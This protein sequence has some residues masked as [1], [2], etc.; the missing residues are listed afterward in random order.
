MYQH[1]GVYNGEDGNETVTDELIDSESASGLIFADDPATTDVLSEEIDKCKIHEDDEEGSSSDF[2]TAAEN[3]S[4]DDT[5][6][7]NAFEIKNGNCVI[8]QKDS[9]KQLAKSETK[10]NKKVNK[11]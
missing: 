3:V 8:S 5:T 4:V 1:V 9:D 7:E 11:A 2:E 6:D 10:K